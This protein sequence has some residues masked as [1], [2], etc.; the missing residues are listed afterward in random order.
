MDDVYPLALQIFLRPVVFLALYL[1]GYVLVSASVVGR[2]IFV[3]PGSFWV[4]TKQ[5]RGSGPEKN[6]PSLLLSDYR[7]SQDFM[8]KF[9]DLIQVVYVQCSFFDLFDSH[10][11]FSNLTDFGGP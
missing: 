9:P 2:K 7:K 11:H 10:I 5:N 1:K 8:V 6:M 3:L 4:E